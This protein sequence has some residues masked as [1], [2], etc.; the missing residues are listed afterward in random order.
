MTL[1]DQIAALRAGKTGEQILAILDMLA[2]NVEP[3][4]VAETTTISN[5][6][7]GVLPDP[8]Y[9]TTWDGRQVAF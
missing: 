9:I 1:Q 4:T 2:G 8:G 3:Q 5:A 6:L 7:D